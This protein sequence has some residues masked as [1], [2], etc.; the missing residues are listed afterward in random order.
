MEKLTSR[1]WNPL[2]VKEKPW[3]HCDFEDLPVG[4]LASR[5][6]QSRRTQLKN[7]DYIALDGSLTVVPGA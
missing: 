5:I 2:D 3:I 6:I 1:G 4:Y 7:E